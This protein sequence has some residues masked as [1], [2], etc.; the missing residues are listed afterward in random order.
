MNHLYRN[1][2]ITFSILAFLLGTKAH[3]TGTAD[4]FFPQEMQ[5]IRDT[6]NQ[7]EDEMVIELPDED[8]AAIEEHAGK[9]GIFFQE[10]DGFHERTKAIHA[11]ATLLMSEALVVISNGAGKVGGGGTGAAVKVCSVTRG[12]TLIS[13]T[14][15]GVAVLLAIHAGDVAGELLHDMDQK[16]NDGRVYGS[17]VDGIIFIE[18]LLFD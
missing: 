8:Y 6:W 18:N 3:A 13:R 16:Y 15:L 17:I 5:E 2:L 11:T 12:C 1:L 10:D 9:R 7:P 14:A 4:A